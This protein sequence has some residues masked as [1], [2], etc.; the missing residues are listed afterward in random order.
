VIRG[1]VFVIVSTAVW[2]LF[3]VIWCLAVIDGIRTGDD[4]L[5]GGAALLAV[6]SALLAG[7]GVVVALRSRRA[8]APAQVVPAS[9]PLPSRKSAAGSPVYTPLN[10]R[11]PFGR[12]MKAMSMCS[13]RMSKP[14]F[15]V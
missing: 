9:R 10:S 6:P 12:L 4:E 8:S 11:S 5:V 3:A 15:I 7:A 1:S 14:N 2:T 13:R